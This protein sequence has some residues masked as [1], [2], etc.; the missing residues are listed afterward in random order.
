MTLDFDPWPMT[1]K[2][3]RLLEVQRSVVHHSTCGGE[4]AREQDGK[5]AKKPELI[6]TP[7]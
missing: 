2:F 6:C 4:S 3:N 5:G 7:G 1:S